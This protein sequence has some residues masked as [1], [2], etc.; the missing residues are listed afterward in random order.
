M[1]ACE[2][3]TDAV[4]NEMVLQRKEKDDH[5]KALDKT[6]AA[7]AELKK[8]VLEGDEQSGSSKK[9][10]CIAAMEKK[11]QSD[12]DQQWSRFVFHPAVPFHPTEDAE[13]DDFFI[14]YEC[15]IVARLR[16]W[17]TP[18]RKKI[19]KALDTEYETLRTQVFKEYFAN[20]D[21]TTM[22]SDGWSNV[23]SRPMLNYTVARTKGTIFMHAKYPK[24]VKK[25]AE[26]VAQKLV[27]AKQIYEILNVG[28]QLTTI[29]QDNA[30]VMS[31]ANLV[32]DSKNKEG[33]GYLQK[34]WLCP[35]FLVF[36]VQ[37]HAED[38]SH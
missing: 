30:S 17:G 26:Y 2:S 10:T 38:W 18:D 20:D 11:M 21:Y 25:D 4:L 29:V 36:V 7:K 12:L 34:D 35:A 14:M 16:N 15:Y 5:Q 31:A 3:V 8:S 13:L 27:E 19:G 28:S 24:L 6:K 37:G 1:A 22:A 32:L 33:M 9:Q 23:R